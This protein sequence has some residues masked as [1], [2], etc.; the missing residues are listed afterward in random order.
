MRQI[1][2]N[3]HH[4]RFPRVLHTA[5][6][7]NEAIREHPNNIYPIWVPEHE[8]LHR[9]VLYTPPFPTVIAQR[10]LRFMDLGFSPDEKVDAYVYAVEEA[11]RHP[12]TNQLDRQ[13]GSL[14]IASMEEQRR[15]LVAGEYM[16]ID[17]RRS[18]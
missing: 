12:R 16:P 10:V 6:P 18:A 3:R 14:A 15:F 9:A 2:H 11:L 1:E 13:L 8:D 17:T 7:F 4:A 5:D